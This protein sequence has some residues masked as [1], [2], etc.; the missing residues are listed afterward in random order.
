MLYSLIEIQDKILQALQET[1]LMVG[2]SLVVAVILG[3]LLGLILFASNETL[4][5]KNRWV[6]Q[7]LGIVLNIVRSVPFLILMIFL[8][9][10]SVVIVGTKIGSTAVI[11]PL[12]IAAIAFF[13]RLSEASFSEV[14]KGVLEAAIASGAKKSHIIVKILIPEALPSLIKNITVT[15]ISVLGFSAMAGLVGGG[16][17]GDLAYRYGYQRY[18]QEVMIL[19]VILLIILVQVIQ[20]VGDL[21]VKAVDRR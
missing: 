11:V 5:N 19:C 1:A 6:Y 8:L 17:I 2:V 18:E 16:G 7:I 10:L 4:F 14:N 13:G 15:A 20:V 9:P 3:G 21:L 12:S